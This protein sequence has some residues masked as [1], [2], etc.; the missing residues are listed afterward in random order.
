M[1]SIFVKIVLWF[2]VTVVVGVAGSELT[3]RLFRFTP[4]RH[5][6]FS[7]S[8]AGSDDDRV[9]VARQEIHAPD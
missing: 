3:G 7:K 6:F 5:D 9:A 1:R 8:L 2:C 4:G